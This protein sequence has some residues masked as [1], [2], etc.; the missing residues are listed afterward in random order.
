[1]KPESV[2]DISIYTNCPEAF[3][4]GMNG[5]AWQ[6][7]ACALDL[8]A[9]YDYALISMR[10]IA[11]RVGVR[12]SSIYN[13]FSSKE[14]LLNKM[15]DYLEHYSAQYRKDMDALLRKAETEPPREVLIST[16]VHYPPALQPIMSR[17]ILVTYKQIRNDARADKVLRYLLVDTPQQY[18]RALLGRMLELGRIKPLD[19]DAFAELYTNN[20]Y[21]AALRMH[22]SHPVDGVV[23]WNSF[24]MLFDM[25]EPTGR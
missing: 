22:S 3:R 19:V 13:H 9:E 8:F 5:T 4:F 2:Q 1:M 6:I 17:L 20:Y 25:I 7:F 23:W 24:T 15:Y 11:K 10:Q 12:A 16:H 18:I 14:A 21:G